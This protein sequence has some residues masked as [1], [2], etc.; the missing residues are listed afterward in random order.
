MVKI[1]SIPANGSVV[2][3]ASYTVDDDSLKIEVNEVE[4]VGALADN[5]ILNTDKDYKAKVAFNIKRGN[6][7]VNYEIV[8]EAPLNM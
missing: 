2:I 7:V 1:D 3:N 6:V 8:G 5:S 4:L